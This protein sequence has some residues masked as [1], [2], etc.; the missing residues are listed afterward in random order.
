MFAGRHHRRSAGAVAVIGLMTGGMAPRGVPAGRERRTRR[1]ARD[2]TKVA[3]G[4]QQAI[5][6]A[7]QTQPSAL[8]RSMPAGLR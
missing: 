5:P 3:G 6:S 7:G 4:A 2:P 1:P 8:L